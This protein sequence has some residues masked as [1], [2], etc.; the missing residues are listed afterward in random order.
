MG[1]R[2]MKNPKTNQIE[3]VDVL[4]AGGEPK[5]IIFSTHSVEDIKEV[6]KL[7]N[8]SEN[9]NRTTNSRGGILNLL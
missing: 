9:L 7:Y 5:A 8:E 6:N 2:I 4:K 1:Q 3:L